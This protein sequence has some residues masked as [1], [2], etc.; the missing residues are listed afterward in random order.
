MA[1]VILG[2]K[3][4]L[5]RFRNTELYPNIHCKRYAKKTRL[6]LQKYLVHAEFI[7]VQVQYDAPPRRL[8]E[9]LI[10]CKK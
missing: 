5:L 4:A 3:V 6:D 7:E 1:D 9:K 8:V 10:M 2:S